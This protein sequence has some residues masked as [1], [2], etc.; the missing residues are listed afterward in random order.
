MSSTGALW[1]GTD[2]GL[3]K[4]DNNSINQYFTED[5]LPLNAIWAIDED[6]NQNVWIGTYGGGVAKF[7]NNLFTTINTSSGLVNNEIVSLFSKDTL[8]Y[9]GT[10]DGLSVFNTKTQKLYSHKLEQR[11]PFRVEQFF[12]HRDTVY[13]VTYNTGI[14]QIVFRKKDIQL[15]EVSNYNET[16]S[17]F[18][19]SDKLFL[20]KKEYFTVNPISKVLNK[21]NSEKKHDHLGESII[22]DFA[23]TDSQIFGAAWGIYSKDGGIYEI[24]NDSMQLRNVDFNVESTQV[25]SLAYDKALNRLHIGTLDL[26]YY[27]VQ[28]DNNLLFYPSQ[29]NVIIDYAH[30]KSNKILATLYDSCL[31]IG[32]STISKAQLKNWQL[33]YTS[34]NQNS[35]P[36]HEDYFYELDYQTLS[37]DIV[38]YA[39]KYQNG[40]FWLNTSI[41]I[42]SFNSDASFKNYYPLHTLEFNFTSDFELIET[43]PYH[44]LRVYKD[45][46]KLDYT[47]F[48][49]EHPNTPTDVVGSL[50]TKDK[51]YFLSVFK[52]LFTYEDG[53]FTSYVKDGIWEE[54]KLRHIT[55]FNNRLAISNESG[56]VFIISDN[57]EGIKP[58]KISRSKIFGNTISFLESY[59]ATLIV[60]TEKGLNLIEED[61]Y[62]FINEE[63]GL[64]GK[65][66]SAIVLKDYLYIGS[67]GGHYILNLPE[68]LK[69]SSSPIEVYIDEFKVN[70]SSR[71]IDFGKQTVHLNHTENSL[72]FK[73]GTN[74]HPYPDK[75]SFAYRLNSKESYKHL[76]GNTITLPYLQP[77]HYNLSIKVF[78]SSKGTTTQHQ[79]GDFRLNPPFY[80]TFWFLSSS[81]IATILIVILYFKIKQLNRQKKEQ[82]KAA[83]TKRLEELKLEALLAQMNPHFIFNALNSI[84]YYISKS[85]NDDAMNYLSKFSTL[86]RSNLNNSSKQYWSLEEEI[87]YLKD[88]TTLEN[89]RF[90]N[91]IEIKFNVDH[92]LDLNDTE[93]PT[94]LLQPFVENAF[95]HAFPSRIKAPKLVIS[96]QKTS[97]HNLKCVVKDNGIGIAS[98][99]KKQHHTSKGLQLVKERLSFLGYDTQNCLNVSL[100]STGTQVSLLLHL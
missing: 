15:V 79:I 19:D 76:E 83:V 64:K 93:I 18:V 98:K 81:F 58:E 27:E 65:L 2:N 51:T 13:A 17:A 40:L 39:I 35:L 56:D 55:K 26:G 67:E 43:N 99:F 85:D 66:L 3:V 44:G 70:G 20:G 49:E 8:V 80:K 84:Q 6:N 57:T 59:E 30:S 25:T 97:D 38:L 87:D 75:L 37:D 32:E 48:S 69:D 77:N 62:I 86:L 42:Y 78:D 4:K 23:K 29:H 74:K 72:L 96:I 73:I 7:K 10:S 24:L 54:K 36:K 52:G 46:G 92:T 21:T 31:D 50:H 47:Y 89:L 88:Y 1:I 5:G 34:T 9:I 94:M 68:L 71:N 33:Q 16:Y 90:N 63:Q 14:H 60:G 61:R 100:N 28:L 41:G 22:W 82:E 53:E 95:V 12:Q 11:Q 45:A 91:K